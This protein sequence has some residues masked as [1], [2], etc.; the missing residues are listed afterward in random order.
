MDRKKLDKLRGEVA[1]LW[2]KPQKA[3]TLE[4]V[5]KR[6][7]R[8]KVKRGKEPVWESELGYPLS[9]PHHSKD[10]PKGTTNSI[11]SVFEEDILAWENKLEQNGYANEESTD[12]SR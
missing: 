7:G 4:S 8:K 1:R 2:N 12:D 9:I 3:K 11:L 6:L 5:A 10:V